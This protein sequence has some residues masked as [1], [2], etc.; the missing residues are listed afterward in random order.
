MRIDFRD[1]QT[2]I[3]LKHQTKTAS[4]FGPVLLSCLAGVDT[5]FYFLDRLSVDKKNESEFVVLEQLV[6]SCFIFLCRMI[7]AIE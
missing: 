2:K 5:L 1:Y 4:L 6:F 3:E 7:E